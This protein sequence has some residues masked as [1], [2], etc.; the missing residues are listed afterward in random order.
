MP[1]RKPVDI[2]KK[3]NNMKPILNQS[4]KVIGYTNEVGDRHEVRSR[5]NNLVAWHDQRQDKT[6]KRDGSMVGFGNQAIK[7]LKED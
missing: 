6:F 7:F 1:Q 4:G 5:S 3:H 2:N